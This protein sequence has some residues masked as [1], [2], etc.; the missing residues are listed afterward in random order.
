MSKNKDEC[1]YCGEVADTKDHI[2]PISKGG[3]GKGTVPACK[4]C[5]TTRGNVPQ[6]D[7]IMFMQWL[8]I[9]GFNMKNVSKKNRTALK[10]LFY[11]ETGI[12]IGIPEE[13]L[14]SPK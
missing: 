7:Y 11:R 2:I 12:R 9:L 5:N 4:L 6:E 3:K 10:R 1:F 8:N 13:H 14:S